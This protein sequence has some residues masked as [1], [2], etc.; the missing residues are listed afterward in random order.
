MFG[1]FLKPIHSKQK[2]KVI[3]AIAAAGSAKGALVNPANIAASTGL[4]LS[5]TTWLLNSV[6]GET[7]A[8]LEVD[9]RGSIAYKFS[10][11]FQNAYILNGSRSLLRAFGRVVVNTAMFAFKLITAVTYALFRISFGIALILG[12][13]IVVLSFVAVI[14]AAIASIFGDNGGGGGDGLAI[15]GAFSDGGSGGGDLLG[16]F[17]FSWFGHLDFGWHH[18]GWC[19]WYWPDFSSSYYYSYPSSYGDA[20]YSSRHLA[21]EQQSF[22]ND[23]TTDHGERTDFPSA[24]FSL[25]F[26]DGD[27]NRELKDRY[28][29]Q[30]AAVIRKNLGVVT[31][32]QLAPYT[33]KNPSNED[34]MIPVMVYLGGSPDVTD[35]GNIIYRFPEFQKIDVPLAMQPR[36]KTAEA[37][38]SDAASNPLQNLYLSSLARRAQRSN[39]D[40]RRASQTSHLEERPWKF[41]RV[42]YQSLIPV[43]ACAA[44]TCGG[45]WWLLQHIE[46]WTFLSPIAAVL[47]GFAIYGGIF[48]ILPVVRYMMLILINAGIES[49][50]EMRRSYAAKLIRPDDELKAKLAEA[51]SVRTRESQAAW[52]TTIYSTARDNLAQQIEGAPTINQNNHAPLPTTHG[53]F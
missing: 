14:V 25:L 9:S 15:G 32:E 44:F 43:I 34:W 45:S 39:Q 29:P 10:P 22:S 31:A 30:I 27:P 38:Q 33:G 3:D 16:A 48:L 49:R 46:T 26:G 36:R 41:S 28:W 35:A 50:N 21:I 13:I 42:S 7:K 37:F 19:D 20:R 40:A 51:E 12:T 11:F 24:A 52:G 1:T 6:A 8:H 17:D 5:E 18:H 53:R 47:S 4:S 2:L 23:R